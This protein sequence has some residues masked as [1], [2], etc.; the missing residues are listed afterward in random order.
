[1]AQKYFAIVAIALFSSPPYKTL[2]KKKNVTSETPVAKTI[3]LFLFYTYD[4]GEVTKLPETHE[5]VLKQACV[6]MTHRPTKCTGQH[7]PYTQNA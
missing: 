7:S 5:V 1:M 6:K 3:N 4:H 2:K